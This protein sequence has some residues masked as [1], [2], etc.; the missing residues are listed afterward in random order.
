M[1]NLLSAA[2]FCSDRAPTDTHLSENHFLCI[3]RPDV[4]T[5]QA[6]I[7]GRKQLF[8]KIPWHSEFKEQG[9]QDSYVKLKFFGSTRKKN[10]TKNLGRAGQVLLWLLPQQQASQKHI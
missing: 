5:E 4:L 1:D 7:L 10:K 8:E 2:L 6:S 3:I 9:K